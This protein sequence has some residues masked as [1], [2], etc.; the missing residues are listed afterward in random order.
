M[1]LSVENKKRPFSLDYIVEKPELP[2]FYAINLSF[3]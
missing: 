2:Y 1:V 3:G